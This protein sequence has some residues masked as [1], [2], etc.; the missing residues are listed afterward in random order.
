M[1]ADKDFYNICFKIFDPT[2]SA[3]AKCEKC[4]YGTTLNDYHG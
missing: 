3:T 4:A 2:T 1:F